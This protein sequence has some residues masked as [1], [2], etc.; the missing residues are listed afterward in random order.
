[1]DTNGPLLGPRR[2][3]PKVT[4]STQAPFQWVL[5][6]AGRKAQRTE[7]QARAKAEIISTLENDGKNTANAGSDRE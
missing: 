4:G 6:A 5:W 1:M 7:T 2:Q 3:G